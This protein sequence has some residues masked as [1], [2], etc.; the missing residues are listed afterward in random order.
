MARLNLKNVSIET[1]LNMSDD[2]L[3]NLAK[4]GLDKE[5]LI[6][7]E[8]SKAHRRNLAEITS[9]VVSVANKRI[10]Q[11]GKSEIGRSSPAYQYAKNMSPSGKFS[12]KGQNW[13]QLR[14]TLKETKQ[15]LN[16]K[17]STT[18]GW[19]EVRARIR[20]DVG[21]EI[22]TAYKSKKFWKAYRM[23]SETRGGI[24]GRKGGTGRLT[25]DRIQKLLMNTIT[26]T[27]DENGKR[28]IN[29]RSSVDKIVAQ[30]DVDFENEYKI[31]QLEESDDVGSSR[32]ID[33]YFDDMD[34]E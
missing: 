29:W 20:E 10:R 7:T 21:G 16:Y 5:N 30:A 34:E 4:R 28:S 23:L 24:M 15:W 12:I 1:L 22:D 17:T 19:K 2:E 13:N 8:Y 11:L 18:K 27:R 26:N 25:S 14:N 33:S 6:K 31:A 9:R 3:L 32:V